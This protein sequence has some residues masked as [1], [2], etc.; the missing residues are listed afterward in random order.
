[1]PD[2]FTTDSPA[3]RE[4]QRIAA[5]NRELLTRANGVDRERAA[6]VQRLGPDRVRQIRLVEIAVVETIKPLLEP[7]LAEI[8]RLRER[9]VELE[10]RPRLEYCGVWAAGNVYGKG[11]IVTHGGSA[12]H[13]N[14]QET[15]DEPGKSDAF[16]LMVKRGKDAR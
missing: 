9:I 10:K 4:L 8:K 3:Y 6:L 1:V 5:R 13:C 12:W 11:C 15:S 16:T 14:H 7:L 2:E